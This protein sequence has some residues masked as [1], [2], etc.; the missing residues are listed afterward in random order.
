MACKDD[1]RTATLWEASM[2]PFG[3]HKQTHS[4]AV[5]CRAWRTGVQ[6]R[7]VAVLVDIGLGSNP[8]FLLCFGLN[9][10]D[11]INSQESL[12]SRRFLSF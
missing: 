12:F 3:E 11:L 7:L 8:S 4:F 10:L 1:R 2:I 6:I 5:N 9:C